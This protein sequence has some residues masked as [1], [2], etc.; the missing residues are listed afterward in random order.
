MQY[1]FYYF[2]LTYRCW[3][4]D[5]DNSRLVHY[6]IIIIGLLTVVVSSGTVMLFFV[7]TKIRNWPEWRKNCM[8]F[9][10]IWGLACLFG[11]TWG[12]GLF[13]I[14]PLSEASFFLFCMINSCLGEIFYIVDA[15][16]LLLL[17]IH[18][19]YLLKKV[20]EERS[21]P[22]LVN[23]FVSVWHNIIYNSKLWYQYVFLY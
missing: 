17:I 16:L 21:N 8:A 7:A 20:A 5:S 11:T 22:G 2:F 15:T 23:A 1:I 10:S 6:I 12:L 4:L 3:M 18:Y 13:S 9:F 19:C 14:G